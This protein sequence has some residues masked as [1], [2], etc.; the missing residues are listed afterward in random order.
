VRLLDGVPES[1]WTVAFQWR[2]GEELLAGN[3]ADSKA[4]F[5]RA[6]AAMQSAAEVM[7]RIGTSQEAAMLRHSLG[8]AYYER[9]TDDETYRMLAIQ[10]WEA[11]LREAEQSGSS[12][13]WA[14]VKTNIGFAQ[15]DAAGDDDDALV[16]AVG[17]L[18][19]AQSVKTRETD[20][21][22][23]ADIEYRIGVAYYYA[24]Q[25]MGPRQ[26]EAVEAL[27]NALLVYSRQHTPREWAR[28]QRYLGLL[29]PQLQRVALGYDPMEAG[30]AASMAAATVFTR[31][32]DPKRWA[33]I[34]KSLAFPYL[35]RRRGDSSQNRPSRQSSEHWRSSRETTTSGPGL[36]VSRHSVCVTWIASSGIS[37]IRQPR[38]SMHSR[39]RRTSTVRQVTG[40]R[41][42]PPRWRSD[43]PTIAWEKTTPRWR[44][45][46]GA[47]RSSNN[48]W[49]ISIRR[50]G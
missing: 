31:E 40:A 26:K 27:R 24:A 34:Q 22:G 4:D 42:H 44:R 47:R 15:L 17:V 16:S 11:A 7:S 18:R 39:Q 48:M 49:P 21:R 46:R 13:L 43:W 3:G 14:D 37:G 23:W 8:S 10:Q 1:R 45:S 33:S 41:W 38:L 32:D 6:T 35:H 5:A 28:T 36:T 20:P 12:E 25:D 19:E 30:I 29:Y 50:T 2:L 9:R